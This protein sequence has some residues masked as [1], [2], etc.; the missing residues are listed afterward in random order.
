[1]ATAL[2]ERDISRIEECHPILQKLWY[3]CASDTACPPFTIIDG[4]RTVEEQKAYVARGTSKTMRSRHIPAKNGWSHAIDVAPVIDGELT[5]DWK[6]YHKLEPHVQRIAKTLNIEALEWGGDWKSFKDGPHWQLS[7]AA[8]SG[9]T[10]YADNIEP[11]FEIQR[12]ERELHSDPKP[13]EGVGNFRYSI[14]L[15][16]K[17]EGGFV[18]DPDDV[19]GATNKGITLTTF[20]KYVKP[21]ATIDDLRKLT[22]EQAI[23]VYKQ[24]YWDACRCDMLPA[25]VDHAVFDFAVNSGTGRAKEFLQSVVDTPVDRRIGPATLKAVNA[26]APAK[27]VD[28]LCNKRSVYI[29]DRVVSGK[30][31]KKF[32]KGILLRIE[33]VRKEALDMA[34]SPPFVKPPIQTKEP[35]P[36]AKSVFIILFELLGKLFGKRG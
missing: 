18:N 4:A 21:K 13:R 19:G 36:P 17:H 9:N 1:M 7:W 6:Y 23:D 31:H 8:F 20:R 22:D 3:A 5:W 26:M 11:D 12:I 29:K 10:E 30:L 34:E 2:T 27:L 15:V 16:L 33:R 35:A 28:V 32:E 14:P 24:H 25:G